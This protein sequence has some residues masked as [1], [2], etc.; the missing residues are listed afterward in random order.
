MINVWPVSFWNSSACRRMKPSS[1][2]PGAQGIR[3][4]MGRLGK[5]PWP[6][7]GH[8]SVVMASA[9][10]SVARRPTET[11]FIDCVLPDTESALNQ[12]HKCSAPCF[13][14]LLRTAVTVGRDVGWLRMSLDVD[15]P[16]PGRR[17]PGHVP[18]LDL[19]FRAGGELPIWVKQR[20]THTVRDS[21]K[22]GG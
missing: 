4:R 11:V 16:C 13:P 19:V 12:P 7:A 20:V 15:C 2:P 10:L 21:V 3:N 17:R 8:A 1:V 6:I 18:D 22:R 9:V 14:S 5:R